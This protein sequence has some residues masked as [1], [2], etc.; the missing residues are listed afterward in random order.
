MSNNYFINNY[1]SFF[2]FFTNPTSA[3]EFRSNYDYRLTST[4][5]AQYLGTDNTQVG[6]YGTDNPFTNVPTNPQITSKEVAKETDANGKLSVKFT[7]EA[8]Q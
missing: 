7:V 5:A 2:N 4:A 8:Q 6:L 3:G 1:N